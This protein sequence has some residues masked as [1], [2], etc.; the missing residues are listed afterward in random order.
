MSG[1]LYWLSVS[2]I[3]TRESAISVRFAIAI[4]YFAL[5]AR[6]IARRGRTI[7]LTQHKILPLKSLRLQRRAFT[8]FRLMTASLPSYKRQ[9][10]F[11]LLKFRAIFDLLMIINKAHFQD[12]ICLYSR[13]FTPH[14]VQY[15]LY[16]R[17]PRALIIRIL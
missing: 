16:V 13:D 4:S 5:I 3:Y 1:R 12:D 8:T 10:S 6:L 14:S 15:L 11:F 7:A 17:F 2:A 9:I